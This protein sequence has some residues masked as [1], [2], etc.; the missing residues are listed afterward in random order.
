MRELGFNYRITDFQCA[1]GISQLKKLDGFVKKK[2]E[3][4]NFYDN[5]LKNDERF[6]IPEEMKNAKHSYH[7]YPLQINFSKNKKSKIQIFN[8]LKAKGLNCQVHYIP[9]HTQPYYIDNFGFSNGDYPVAEMFYAKE[10][11]IP[12]YPA[13][14][15]SDLRLI[16][17]TIKEVVV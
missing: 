17:K 4:A 2:R 5:E 12:M 8:E 6:I 11:S 1:L 14:S 7:L 16:T 13:L 9:V 3:I 10:I 15:L